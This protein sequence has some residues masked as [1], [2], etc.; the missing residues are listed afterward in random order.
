M[1]SRFIFSP[2]RM[3]NTAHRKLTTSTG[4]TFPKYSKSF[5]GSWL[6]WDLN[7]PSPC[8]QMGLSVIPGLSCLQQ[9]EPGKLQR[10]SQ[11]ALNVWQNILVYLH[12]CRIHLRS[13]ENTFPMFNLCWLDNW[14]YQRSINN[15]RVVMWWAFEFDTIRWPYWYSEY[16]HTTAQWRTYFS[17]H[18]YVE[19][20]YYWQFQERHKSY[21]EENRWS[22]KV[23]SVPGSW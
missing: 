1:P 7:Q 15:L 14:S 13:F 22:T 4:Y 16:K 3:I 20:T 9:H 21:F 19:K 12:P 6:A 10:L 8:A 5:I 18:Q 23:I 2:S 11:T 17:R